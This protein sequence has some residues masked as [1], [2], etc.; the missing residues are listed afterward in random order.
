MSQL[1]LDIKHAEAAGV[2]QMS[3][4]KKRTLAARKAF[5]GVIFCFLYQGLNVLAGKDERVIR[6]MET[7]EEGFSCGIGMGEGAPALYMEKRGNELVRL[8]GEETSPEKMDLMIQFKSVE[9]AFLVMSGQVGVAGSYARHGFLLKG[10]IAR[11]MSLVRCVD[12]AEGYLFPR[13]IS[14]NI[15]KA[16][17]EKKMGLIRTYLAVVCR[18]LFHGKGGRG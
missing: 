8:S 9:A 12:L 6:E 11:G 5:C 14:R 18:M 3:A 17:P 16:V 4:R 1:E 2:Y 13:F 7:W 10:D 15:L